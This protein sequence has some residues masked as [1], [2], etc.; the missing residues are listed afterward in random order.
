M[1][2]LSVLSA[3]IKPK[4]GDCRANLA[5]VG[6]IFTQIKDAPLPANVRISRARA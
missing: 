4:K 6:Q 3:Q 1:L 2:K 5:I